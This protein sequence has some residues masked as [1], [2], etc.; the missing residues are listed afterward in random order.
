MPKTQYFA[1][2]VKLPHDP[3]NPVTGHPTDTGRYIGPFEHQETARDWVSRAKPPEGCQWQV[4]SM[5]APV[6]CAV[7]DPTAGRWDDDGLPPRMI[8]RPPAWKWGK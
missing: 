5:E 8:R 7:L 4:R 3:F 1:A 2:L 6:L